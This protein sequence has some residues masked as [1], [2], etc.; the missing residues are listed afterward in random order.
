MTNEMYT[1]HFEK[2]VKMMA[3]ARVE[4]IEASETGDEEKAKVAVESTRDFFALF[5][6]DI[7]VAAFVAGAFRKQDADGYDAAVSEAV[8]VINHY[9][10]V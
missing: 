7:L 6:E 3:K 2:F 10:A 1:A 4:V 8:N 9:R 5:S